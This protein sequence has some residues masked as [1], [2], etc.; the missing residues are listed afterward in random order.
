MP[1]A[2]IG[3][4]AVD[5]A[6]KR[7]SGLPAR[8]S[9][10]D[11]T[12]EIAIGVFTRRL[13]EALRREPQGS[14]RDLARMVFAAI[15]AE[16]GATPLPLFDGALDTPLP[17]GTAVRPEPLPARFITR[18]AVS[19]GGGIAARVIDKALTLLP[20]GFERAP[21]S[22]ADIVLSVE[23]GQLYLLPRGAPLVTTRDSYGASPV[24]DLA[25]PVGEAADAL[26]DR[27]WRFGRAGNLVRLAALS[28]ERPAC[29]LSCPLLSDARP[30]RR[31]LPIPCGAAHRA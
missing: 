10:I 17:G 5:R 20:G 22:E 31:A 26:A 9:G 21:P 14:Y 16:E 24:I 23:G 2:L 4:Y 1:G 25:L 28:E 13:V 7:W 27:L 19:D 29:R 30:I 6:R 11:G 18:I 12:G 8:R 15:A 3:F